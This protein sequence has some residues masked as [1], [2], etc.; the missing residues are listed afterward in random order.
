M[1]GQWRQRFSAEQPMGAELAK[2]LANEYPCSAHR[3]DRLSSVN[4]V[5]K[6]AA[7]E[8]KS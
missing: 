1:S 2:P 3:Q 5:L 8:V 4:K 6:R 7:L